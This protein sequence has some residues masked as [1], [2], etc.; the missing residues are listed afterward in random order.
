[1]K[2]FISVLLALTLAVSCLAGCGKSESA[3]E[4]T[5]AAEATAT[6]APEESAAPSAMET[7]MAEAYATYAPETVV[8]TI[9]GED[10]TWERYFSWIYSV[11]R[12]LNNYYGITDMSQE[13]AEGVTCADYIKNYAEDMCAQYAMINVKAVE[14]GCTMSDEDKELMEAA[15]QA[16]AD[17][18]YGGDVQAMFDYLASLYITEDHYR[19]MNVASILFYSIFEHY[20]GKNASNLAEEDVINY[21]NDNGIFHAKHILIK[22]VDDTNQPLDEDTVAEKR[23]QAEALLAELQ[24]VPAEELE[25]KFDALMQEKSE[26][27]GST[28]YPDGYYF[29]SGE[30]V[31]A[32]E[33]A[34]AALEAGQLSGIVESNYGYHIIYRPAMHGDDVYSF[35]SDGSPYTLRSVAADA[36]F[37]NITDEWVKELEIE[38]VNGFD[39]LDLAAMLTLPA[40]EQT[41][42]DAAGDETP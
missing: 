2:K 31:P 20:M 39:T 42:A 27:P 29:T 14:L 22:T 28:A 24:A 30:M 35:N 40:A 7:M 5:P 16:D 8:M 36:L 6:P 4:E 32:F 3:P 18:Y 13:L 12:Q 15:I 34:T 21:A 9:N 25:E 11:Y 37:A 17:E 41:Q 23:A 33:E 10:V 1:M 19:Y 26:D 38:Y